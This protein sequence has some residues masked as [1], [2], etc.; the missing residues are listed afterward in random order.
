MFEW[1]WFVLKFPLVVLLFGIGGALFGQ[2]PDILLV[3]VKFFFWPFSNAP[4]EEQLIKKP[5]IRLLIVLVCW[6]G[7]ATALFAWLKWG[8]DETSFWADILGVKNVNTISKAN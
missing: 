3:V 6:I 2:D 1:F 8:T 4:E 5:S 7:C